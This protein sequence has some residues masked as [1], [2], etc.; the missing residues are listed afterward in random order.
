M[1]K[2]ERENLAKVKTRK[3]KIKTFLEFIFIGIIEK[4][5]QV[6][7]QELLEKRIKSSENGTLPEQLI[8]DRKE[9]NKNW[10]KAVQYFQIIIN[11]ERIKENLPPFDFIVIRNKLVA[12]RNIEDLR[13]FYTECLKYSYTRDKVTKKR[14]TFG[15]CFWGA[16]KVIHTTPLE[17]LDK[18]DTTLYT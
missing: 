9:Y 1:Y 7:I 12:I 16:L 14:N 2:N 17:S 10:A 3:K 15:K 6:S 11:K 13:W 5:M 8:L 18:V 4:V